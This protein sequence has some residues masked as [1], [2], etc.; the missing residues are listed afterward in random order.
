MTDRGP[1]LIIVYLAYWSPGQASVSLVASHTPDACWPG[2]G[3][4][5]FPPSE[6]RVRLTVGGR[7]LAEAE[8]R[9]FKSGNFPQNVW[10]WHLYDGRPIAQS[11]PNSPAELLRLAWRYGFRHD[12][13]Q[14]FI[15]VSSNRSWETV[16]PQPFIR[17]LFAGL[18]PLGL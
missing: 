10:Y 16:A 17:S 1:E 5:A 14:L 18:Q 8:C 12:A 3:W 9:L 15:R 13:D 4:E 7:Q 6:P 11:D 2:S